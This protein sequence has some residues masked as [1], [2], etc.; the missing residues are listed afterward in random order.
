[1][2]D[3]IKYKLWKHYNKKFNSGITKKDIGKINNDIEKINN[4]IRQLS[5]KIISQEYSLLYQHFHFSG[6]TDELI[7][8]FNF[9]EKSPYAWNSKDRRIW[10]VYMS[11]MLE[12][13]PNECNHISRL[14][15][16]YTLMF[17]TKDL[18]KFFPVADFAY[19]SGIS[20]PE[21]EKAAKVFQMMERNRTKDG[22]EKLI[23][24]K[25]VAVVGNGPQE[26]GK[27]KGKE[28]DAH[29]VVIRFNDFQI[30]P[31]DYGT[32]T[33]VWSRNIEFSKKNGKKEVSKGVYIIDKFNPWRWINNFDLCLE[34]DFYDYFPF[35]V[36][37]FYNTYASP[38][39]IEPLVGTLMFSWLKKIRN[40]FDN[41]DFY[42]FSFL[43]EEQQPYTHYYGTDA[44]N[45]EL[46]NREGMR[47]VHHYEEDRELLR[48]LYLEAKKQK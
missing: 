8:Y 13:F 23:E 46:Q 16:H 24:N 44:E 15:D 48:N 45:N 18:E 19:R 12:R 21:I 14:L 43:D 17:G 36:I 28:I 3:K 1:M 37:E 22:F 26:I 27:R 6:P 5:N 31:E 34:N 9:I 47:T 20:T 32:K 11:C 30:F 42:G 39:M 33:D 35:D 41:I 10:L 2:F 40:N 7:S 25:T 4:D 29:D 38:V